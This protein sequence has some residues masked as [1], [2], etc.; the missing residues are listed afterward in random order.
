MVALVANPPREFIKLRDTIRTSWSVTERKLR[1]Q[2]ALAMQ[3]D[4]LDLAFTDTA[5]RCGNENILDTPT[6]TVRRF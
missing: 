2:V 1:A 5:D 4:L 6:S 3:H